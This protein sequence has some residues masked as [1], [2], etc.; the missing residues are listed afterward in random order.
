MPD[1]Y[2]DTDDDEGE[3]DGDP[4]SDEEDEPTWTEEELASPN[5]GKFKTD[6]PAFPKF[7]PTYPP[8]PF[9]IPL[10][11]T[12]PINFLNLYLD[13]HIIDEFVTN[14]NIFGQELHDFL[15]K[16]NLKALIRAL[17]SPLPVPK[18][19][20]YLVSFCTWE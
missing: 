8:G 3:N 17:G 13:A 12:D 16:R 2:D 1:L 19:I 14:T 11:T 5:T 10:G 7:R 20:V 15:K 4:D 9:N 18:F 6:T